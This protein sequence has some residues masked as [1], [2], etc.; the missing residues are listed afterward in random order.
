M[1]VVR[2]QRV[3]QNGD[4]HFIAELTDGSRADVECF[5]CIT[6]VR[7]DMS[8]IFLHLKPSSTMPRVPRGVPFTRFEL[9]CSEGRDEYVNGVCWDKDCIAFSSRVLSLQPWRDYALWETLCVGVALALFTMAC[10]LGYA[11]LFP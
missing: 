10:F 3:F 1:A 4:G 7:R 9:T 11:F 2:V 5:N 8:C 6:P